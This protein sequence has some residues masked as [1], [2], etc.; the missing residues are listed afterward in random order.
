MTGLSRPHRSRVAA[1]A[2]GRDVRISAEDPLG[3]PRHHPEEHEVEDDEQDDRED[4]LPDLAQDV[5]AT[6]SMTSPLVRDA[7]TVRHSSSAA[8]LPR[9]SMTNPTASAATSTTIPTISRTGELVLLV[10]VGTGAGAADAVAAGAD[11]T[12]A[13]D[14]PGD[15]DAAADALGLGA[16][17]LAS[18]RYV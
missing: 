6:Q 3:G 17:A 16:G 9:R 12:A 10:S 4:R 15:D 8:S 1:I 14:A 5:P 18:V 2:P 13:S 7:G 11:A